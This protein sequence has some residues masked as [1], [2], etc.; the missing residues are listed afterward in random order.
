MV[1]SKLAQLTTNHTYQHNI[2]YENA[3]EI[4]KSIKGIELS[5]DQLD[6]VKCALSAGV[7]VITG[8]PGT[9]KTT[10]VNSIIWALEQV[11]AKVI[12]AAPTGRAAKRLT[13]ATDHEASTIHRLLEY[14]YSE[15]ES[16]LS[17]NK[18]E[19][20]QLECDV[21]IVDEMSMVDIVLMGS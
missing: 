4:I 14:G 20:N 16:V 19:N 15:D 18:N 3:R 1:A 10:I 13:L 8:G 6:A 2:D 11:G 12:L 17:F 9:G 5:D 7:S 21:L